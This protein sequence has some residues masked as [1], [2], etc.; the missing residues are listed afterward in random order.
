[1]YCQFLFYKPSLT[2]KSIDHNSFVFICV[3]LSDLKS[4]PGIP[5]FPCYFL[6][7]TIGRDGLPIYP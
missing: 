5:Y 6:F 4:D 2:I 3:N 1:M 7:L